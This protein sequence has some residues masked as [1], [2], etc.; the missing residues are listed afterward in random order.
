MSCL[1]YYYLHHNFPFQLGIPKAERKSAVRY[2][3]LKVKDSLSQDCSDAVMAMLEQNPQSRGKAEDLATLPW[4]SGFYM[5]TDHEFRNVMHPPFVPRKYSNLDIV[6]RGH[7][8]RDVVHR[9]NMTFYGDRIVRGFDSLYRC[10]AQ[11][12]L[13]D[14]TRWREVRANSLLHYQRFTGGLSVDMNTPDNAAQLAVY[15]R[16]NQRI[17]EGVER[18]FQRSDL[19]SPPSLIRIIADTFTC[20]AV[21]IV[22]DGIR[23]SEDE[24]PDVHVYGNVHERR[25]PHVFQIH[26][27]YDVPSQAYDLV[28]LH[29]S[30][31][32]NLYLLHAHPDM[33]TSIYGL[34]DDHKANIEAINERDR[35]AGR[36]PRESTP[37]KTRSLYY[38][39]HSDD[40]PP[41]C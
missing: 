35:R 20:Q 29:H 13:G 9:F 3:E 5:D 17:P 19:L 41:H 14:Q 15:Q 23:R 32:G 18:C 26:L 12:V 2:G 36:H 10:F 33:D 37:H 31:W 24:E 11:W 16:I 8:I 1:I 6:R 27:Y 39:W 40:P 21:V 34:D 28:Q 4:N 30:D 25:P 38:D 22:D 7:S